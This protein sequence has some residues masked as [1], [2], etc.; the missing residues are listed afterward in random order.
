MWCLSLAG[1]LRAT[2]ITSDWERLCKFLGTKFPGKKQVAQ[3]KVLLLASVRYLNDIAL[4]LMQ[5]DL[6]SV[7]H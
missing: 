3:G 4:T 1:T 2:S 7:V 6:D 5:K